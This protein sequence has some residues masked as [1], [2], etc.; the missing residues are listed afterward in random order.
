MRAD[1]VGVI[2][3]VTEFYDT[4]NPGEV[5]RAPFTVE[6]LM[7]GECI[8]GIADRGA[9]QYELTERAEVGEERHPTRQKTEVRAPASLRALQQQFPKASVGNPIFLLIECVLRQAH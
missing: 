8:E 1:N 6:M 3:C 2:H 5:G 4:A 7:F 9:I